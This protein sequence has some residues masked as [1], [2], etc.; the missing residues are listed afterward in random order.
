MGSNAWIWIVVVIIVIIILI[1]LWIWVHPAQSSNPKPPVSDNIF[2]V[3]VAEKTPDNKN[4]GKGS[5]L[6]FVINGKES[7]VL[8]LKEGQTYRFVVRTHGHPFYLTTSFSGGVG[9]PGAI[10]EPRVPMESGSF[11]LIASKD[12][13]QPLYYECALHEYMGARI[14]VE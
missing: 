3:T 1:L 4:Y 10:G 2:N 5:N 13:P 11:P 6:C 7:K 8:R 9:A 12:L 14:I